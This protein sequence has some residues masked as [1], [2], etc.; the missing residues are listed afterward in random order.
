MDVADIPQPGTG[1]SRSRWRFAGCELDELHLRLLVDGEPVELDR[2]SFDLLLCLLRNAGRVVGKDDLLRA[3][4]PGR[5]VSEN[6]LVKAISR[7]RLALNDKGELLRVVSGYGYRLVAEVERLEID[8]AAADATPPMSEP[9]PGGPVVEDSA[10]VPAGRRSIWIPAALAALA[11]LFALA[12][13]NVRPAPVVA[14]KPPM[15]IAVLPLLDYSP[16]KDQAQFA[17]GLAEELLDNLARL[18]QLRV[19]SRTS[20]FAYRGKDIEVPAIGRALNADKVLEGSVRRSGDRMRVTVQLINSA[21]GYHEWSQTFDRHVVEMFAMQDEITRAIV[22]ALRIELLPDQIKGLTRDAT[23]DP[24]EYE[25]L[26]RLHSQYQDDETGG[27]R[28]LIAARRSLELAP[29]SVD[30]MFTLADLLGHIGMYSDSDVEALAG[31]REA[32]EL[33]NR[34]VELAPERADVILLRADL[35]YAHWWDWQGAEADLERA[36]AL[37]A[38][39]DTAY[40]LRLARLRA[41]TGRMDEALAATARAGEVDPMGAGLHVRGYHMIANGD[42]AQAAKVLGRA[43]QLS[44]DDE[45]AHYY[46]GLGELLQ[47]R[48][49]LAITHFENSAH[50]LRLTGMALAMHA[51]DDRVESDR[52]LELLISRYGHILPYQAAEVHAW[53]GESDLA[54]Q[55]FD[56]SCELH[57]ASIMYL[58]FDPLL[59]KLR[60]DPRFDELLRRVNLPVPN[61]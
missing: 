35:K 37:G 53:R 47:G 6:S 5:V 9:V 50:V 8:E 19:V 42:Y 20:S 59:G 33:M 60:G 11:I 61:P 31:K 27:R 2:S 28:A 32:L 21:D 18:P 16:G 41:A 3:G 10:P 4:W 15:S 49:Q 43:L 23:D 44:P 7:L 38:G 58:Q 36:R 46:L 34:A 22:T 57:D 1:A 56:R 39:D 17:D 45:H 25:R 13:V 51:L 24:A 40:L 30:A 26:Y 54:F 48:P 29:D 12:W 52:Y 55:W 14:S